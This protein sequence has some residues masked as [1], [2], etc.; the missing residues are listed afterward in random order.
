MY[1]V[2]IRESDNLNI[3]VL[4]LYGVYIMPLVGNIGF[5]AL[6]RGMMRYIQPASL[7]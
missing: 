1:S 6:G 3:F 7:Q 5:E 4:L 2:T